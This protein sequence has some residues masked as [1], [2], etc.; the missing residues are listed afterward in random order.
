[1]TVDRESSTHVPLLRALL[2]TDLCDSTLLV[3]R[4]GDAAAAALF[5][6]H[7]RLVLA[8]QQRWHGQQID[9]SDGLFLLFERPIDALGFALDYQQGLQVLGAGNGVV[10][11]AR[12]GLHVGEV[13]LWNNS[14]EAVAL[15]SKQVEVEGLAKPMAARLMQMA[16]PGQILVSSTAE[17]MLRRAAADLGPVGDNLKWRSFGRWRF[18]GVAQ[19]MGVL[20]VQA[21]T[22]P[23]ARRPRQTAK[24][25]RDVPFWRRPMAVAAEAMVAIVL[26]VGLWFLLRPQPAI[27]F[28]ERDWVVLADA[29]NLTDNPLLDEGLEQALR[30]T[31]EQS[32]HV[33]VLSDLKARDTLTRMLLPESAVI[34]RSLAIRIAARD[35]ARAVL[36]PSVRE[37]HGLLRVSV[38]VVDPLGG[39][40]VYTVH[41]DGRGY[42][43]AL[44]STDEVAADLRERLGEALVEVRKASEPLP[45]VATGD[46]DALNAYAKGQSAYGAGR[47]DES[48]KFYTIATD[49]DPGFAMAWMARMR[50]LV[51]RGQRDQARAVLVKV[52][53]LKNRLT[54][55]ERLYLEAWRLE[56]FSDSE[57][58]ALGAWQTLAELYPDHHGAN[59]NHALAAFA[60]GRYEEARSAVLRA[61][62]AQNPLRPVTLQLLGRIQLARGELLAAV[63]TQRKALATGKDP[64]TRHLAAALAAS[65]DRAAARR[66]LASLPADGPA[67]WLEGVTLAVDE[68]RHDEA[69]RAA[70]AAASHCRQSDFVCQ[71]LSAVDLAAHA[72]AGQC[73][74]P[75]YVRA[76][77]SS[78]LASATDAGAAD[79][80]GRLFFAAA[81]AYAAQRMGLHEAVSRVIPRMETLATGLADQKALEMTALVVANQRRLSGDPAAARLQLEAMVNGT[82]LF[83]VH[84]VLAKVHADLGDRIAA[85]RQ[86]DWLHAHRGLAYAEFSGSAVLQSLNVRDSA[87]LADRRCAAAPE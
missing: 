24:A 84:S 31:L 35:G 18:K 67:G 12:A 17:S 61:D 75:A 72:A 22:M 62:V 38:E 20:G 9:R 11:H 85:Q 39:Q 28:V 74:D 76:T 56:M 6:Q 16:R 3:E 64:S 2:F 43:S 80:G 71:L 8:L 52:E 59:V 60:L 7:D 15:G 34:D 86:T 78:L 66:T 36:V 29:Q 53:G 49:I 57:T 77:V 63:E 32:R 54:T 41:A 21:A 68:G 82:E 4:I 19:S 46:L 13:I 42:G 37:V 30:I 51:S 10:L 65:G 14:P 48:M 33:N 45:K 81:A 79:R 73:P 87:S 23:A 5:Q 1:M 83:Q 47:V 50:V 25:M 70:S 58:A 44:S 26:M 69:V 27:A 55:R 40:S